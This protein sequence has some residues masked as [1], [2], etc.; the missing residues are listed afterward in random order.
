VLGLA[1]TATLWEAGEAPPAVAESDSEVGLTV[2]VLI[3]AETVKVTV[4]E[5]E[6]LLPVTVT[7]PL[8]V[9]A[10]SPVTLAETDS[11]AG[12]VPVPGETV[13]QEPPLALAVNVV[14]GVA[15][16]ETLWE[17]GEAPPAVA[18]SDSEVGLTVSVLTA[19]ETVKVTVTERER[20]LPV[21]VTVPL[22]VPA[23]NPVTLA[24]T[25]SVAGVV[26][27]PGETVSQ[28]PPLALAVNVEFGVALT[29]TF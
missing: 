9:P 2:S 3:A 14:L 29:E 27:V 28:E 25:D 16:T 17:A 19:A 5:R 8:Y 11:V 12:V 4:T 10:A 21:T 13:S 22:Y 7:V 1:L 6:R 26:P 20:P 23:A 15:L 18:E 24:F